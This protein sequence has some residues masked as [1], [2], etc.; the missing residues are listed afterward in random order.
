MLQK[1]FGFAEKCVMFYK[2]SNFAYFRIV[3]L[4]Y[5]IIDLLHISKL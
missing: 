3:F 2:I 5:K 4:K 1:Y